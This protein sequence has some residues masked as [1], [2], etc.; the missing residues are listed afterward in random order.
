MAVP[1]RFPTPAAVAPLGIPTAKL[2]DHRL[3]IFGDTPGMVMH[4]V[5]AVGLPADSLPPVTPQLGMHALAAHSIPF[6]DLR[7]R[8]PGHDCPSASPALVRTGAAFT[9]GKLIERPGERAQPDA[10]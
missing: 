5:A 1:L 2:T 8:N 10:V 3:D 4:P 9:N 6:G 7:H